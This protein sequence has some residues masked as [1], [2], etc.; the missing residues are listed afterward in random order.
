MGIVAGGVG[1]TILSCFLF[2]DSSPYRIDVFGLAFS[3]NARSFTTFASRLERVVFTDPAFIC[4]FALS[5]EDFFVVPSLDM[6]VFFLLS[7]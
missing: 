4:C 7:V 3:G 1:T 2:A 5:A 6:T